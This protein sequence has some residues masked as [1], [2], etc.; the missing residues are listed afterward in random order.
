M[1]SVHKVADLE[2][3]AMV[4]ESNSKQTYVL[5][6]GQKIGEATVKEILPDRVILR[7]GDEDVPL[8]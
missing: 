5:T 3:E 4:E 8:F 7:V 2:P 1:L 6:P